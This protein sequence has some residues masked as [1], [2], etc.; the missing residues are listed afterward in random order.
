VKTELKFNQKTIDEAE[1]SIRLKIKEI[2][3]SPA[4]LSEVADVAIKDI[5]FQTRRGL[6]PDGNRFKPLSPKWIKERSKIEQATQVHEAFKANRSNVTITG[7]LLDAMS[8][9]ITRSGIAIVFKG[10]HRPYQA[11]RVRTSGNR[12][13]GKPIDN[14]KLAGYVNEVRPFFKIRESLLP[15][16]KNIVIRYIRRKL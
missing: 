10:L 4:L 7:Q 8:K 2:V 15:R 16:L 14:D 1:A 13:I 5:Q 11:K 3:K 12:T 6:T 9:I